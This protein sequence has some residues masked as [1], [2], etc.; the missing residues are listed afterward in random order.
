MTEDEEAR[1]IT[2]YNER[3][4]AIAAEKKA[5]EERKRLEEQRL[6][7]EA[8]RRAYEQTFDFFKEQ[9]RKKDNLDSF[10]ARSDFYD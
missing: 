7:E 9:M 5:E 4:K 1:N 3:V 10:V 2:T 6:K 8:D